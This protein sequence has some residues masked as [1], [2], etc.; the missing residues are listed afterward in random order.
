MYLTV[1]KVT[2]LKHYRQNITVVA[3]WSLA[4]CYFCK[5]TPCS[6]TYPNMSLHPLIVAVRKVWYSLKVQIHH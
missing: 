1:Y 6:Q 5:D 2:D 3:D 4:F